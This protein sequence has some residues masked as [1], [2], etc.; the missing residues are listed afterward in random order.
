MK[1]KEYLQD[2]FLYIFL[3][4]ISSLL[5]IT[6]LFLFKVHSL[7]TLFIIF[8]LLLPFIITIAFDY[9]R[10]SKFYNNLKQILDKLDQKY[11][12]LEIIKSPSFREGK[13]LYDYLYQI[14]K[15]MI[16]NINNYKLNSE[17][18]IEYLEMWCHEIKTPLQ[19]S[20][21]LIENNQNH[22]TKS[23]L[24]ELTK[25]EN[26][27]DQVMYYARSNTVEKD[28]LIKETDLNKVIKTVLK[29][30]QK[31]I[32]AKKIKLTVKVKDKVYSDTKWLEFIINQILVNSIKYTTKDPQIE[33]TSI[34]NKESIVLSIKDNGIGIKK[35]DLSK[36]FDK[37]FTGENGRKSYNSTGL[38][39]YL[40]K[41]LC[42]KLG[43]NITITSKLD[44]G[45]TVNIIFP[46]NSMT[47]NLTKM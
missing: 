32:L 24:E 43:H 39:L 14:N 27:I 38:G 37:S 22:V 36:V 20:K 45:T 30:N 6:I 12:I 35:E 33:I 4:I 13:L 17:E 3:Y 44:E 34:K 21:L 26:Y 40:A 10:K 16:E 5:I 28:Y 11:L 42:T 46:L 29:K 25:I 2:N 7:A 9:Y 18:F 41:K 8:F 1:L 31:D 23:L 47:A 19:T 15:S